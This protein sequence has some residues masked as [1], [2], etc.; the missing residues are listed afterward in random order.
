MALVDDSTR[1][2]FMYLFKTKDEALTYFKFFQVDVENLL[3]K[4]MKHLRYDHVESISQTSSTHSMKTKGSFLRRD[5]P[6]P[7]NQWD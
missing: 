5:L 1:F 3:E 6:I 7:H 4:K 2:C